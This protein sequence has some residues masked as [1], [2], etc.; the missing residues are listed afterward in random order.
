MGKKV[1]I[2]EDQL[3]EIL[4]GSY[5]EDPEGTGKIKD[6][7]YSE[8]T[9]NPL[10]EGEPVT[11]DDFGH[12]ECASPF[13]RYY[14]NSRSPYPAAGAMTMESTAINE[15][16]DGVKNKHYKVSG[17]LRD[18]MMRNYQSTNGRT[19]GTKRLEK[20][21]N[22]EGASEN[23]LSNLLSDINAGKVSNEELQLLGG[24]DFVRWMNQNIKNRQ[25]LD[26]SMKKTQHDMGVENV[27][28]KAGGTKDGGGTAHTPKNG[29][30]MTY[31][32]GN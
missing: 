17:P 32:F 29:G 4:S 30:E 6:G 15:V 2:T 16:A 20:L 9:T 22:N 8:I 19:I 27:Y 14:F 1:Y 7:N 31:D 21:L 23:Y 28:Q 13:W 26:A 12:E 11:T 5:L 25:N 3:N 18:K 10:P 24:D